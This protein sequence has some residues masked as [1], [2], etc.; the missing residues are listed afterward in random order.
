MTLLFSNM[1]GLFTKLKNN[2]FREEEQDQLSGQQSINSL[3]IS[4]T[5]TASP[6][7]QKRKYYRFAFTHP[8]LGNM[9]VIEVGN[10]TVDVG[11]AGILIQDVSLR[12]LK[13]Q[14]DLSLPVTQNMRFLFEFNMMGETFN[15][16]GKIRWK[17]D[18]KHDTYVYGVQLEANQRD[19]ER[20]APIINKMTALKKRN[21][22]IPDTPFYYDDPNRYFI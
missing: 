21:L 7:Q 19:D 2:L 18:G 1:T 4:K 6:D 5:G 20:L 22:E 17:N 13:I 3:R 16:P 10:K 11:K 8:V 15:L 12:G 14:S 9:T